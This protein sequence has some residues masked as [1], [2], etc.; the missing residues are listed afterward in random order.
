MDAK[1]R[2]VRARLKCAS[3]AEYERIVHEAKITPEQEEILRRHIVRGEPVFKIAAALHYCDGT[4]KK[5]LR[6]AY[7]AI[8]NLF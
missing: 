7:A 4:I 2:L 1:H 3:R 8:G 5:K 6:I